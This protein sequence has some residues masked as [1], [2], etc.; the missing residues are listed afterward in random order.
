MANK[1]VFNVVLF[2]DSNWDGTNEE[3]L[4]S[5]YLAPLS[6]SKYVKDIYLCGNP[7]RY[8]RI[9]DKCDVK[10]VNDLNE[11]MVIVMAGNEQEVEGV[12]RF[13]RVG[14]L[15]FPLTNELIEASVRDYLS[16]TKDGYLKIDFADLPFNYLIAEIMGKEFIEDIN[17]GNCILDWEQAKLSNRPYRVD[18]HHLT[19]DERKP[20]LEK[21]EWG[22]Y[23]FPKFIA[24]E[25]T[26]ICNLHCKMCVSH[27]REIDHSHMENYPKHFDMEK[28]KW[29]IDQMTPYN[30]YISISP[31]FQGEPF[32]A[33]HFRAMIDY[34]KSR[35]MSIGFTSNAML[36]DE[37]TIT[38]MIRTGVNHI[39][40]SIDGLKKETFEKIR[41]GANYDKVI[42]NVEKF[43]EL[44]E[45]LSTNSPKTPILVI[46][47]TLLQENK[48]EVDLFLEK[49][50]K[51]AWSVSV[52]NVCVDNIVPVKY[53]AIERYP[54]P[55]LW[56]G[57]HILTNG[58]VIA[59]CRDSKYEEVMGNAY[60]SSI[61]D[62]WQGDKYQKFRK[63][64]IE[65][66][67]NE[68][69][70]CSHCD[71]WMGKTGYPL[72]ED[73]R[74]INQYPF[75]RVYRLANNTISAK[76]SPIVQSD[77]SNVNFFAKM[78][79]FIKAR[80]LNK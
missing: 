64:H 50:L 69:P 66:K 31:Q 70:I 34:A 51:L 59:C 35:D 2:V 11:N 7:N 45:K 36:W 71:T 32:M 30:K 3:L 5:D 27:S 22:F 10:F 60:K 58:D 19:M 65:G 74:I 75:H 29:I 26:R 23:E 41:L 47:M 42:N 79:R 54:C 46:N 78:R 24:L 12:I 62:I 52:S 9:K 1:K 49:W 56:E 18:N 55:F 80:L 73:N 20:Y 76:L 63:L 61:M 38:H 72:Q 39:C 44:R 37:E 13:R 28:Y 43:L 48:D 40:V 67:W 14:A 57:M 16:K 68:I 25:S 15:R 53:Y 8:A 33:P 17:S 21:K 77:S 4:I 6:R